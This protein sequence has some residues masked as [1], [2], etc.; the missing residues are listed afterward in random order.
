VTLLLPEVAHEATVEVNQG[1]WIARCPRAFCTNAEHWGPHPVSEHVGGLRE[2]A[3][4]G[5]TTGS[6]RCNICTWEGPA[7]WPTRDERVAID[8]LLGMRP[9]PMTRNWAP[10]ELVRDLVAE[11]V[12]YGVQSVRG[13]EVNS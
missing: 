7:R 13:P 6:F 10:P 1:L 4:P 3:E 12:K 5:S 8:R 2:P 11:N 9:V